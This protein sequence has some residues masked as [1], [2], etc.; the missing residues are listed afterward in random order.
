MAFDIQFKLIYQ[1]IRDVFRVR[2]LSIKFDA[3]GYVTMVR[4]KEV[5]SNEATVGIYNFA[6]GK[7]FVNYAHKMMER[8]LRV[9][10]EFYVAPVYNMMIEDGKKIAYYNVGAVD[11]GMYGLGIPADLDRFLKN[12]LSRRIFSDCVEA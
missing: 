1:G 11:D 5:I 9:N 7:D 12:E 4:E 3:D 10:N 2:S 6:H 8:N